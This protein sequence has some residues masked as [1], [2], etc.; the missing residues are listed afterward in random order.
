M[1]KHLYQI[2]VL[3]VL[4]AFTGLNVRAEKRIWTLADGTTFEAELVVTFPTEAVF[5]NAKGKDLKIPL[6]RLSPESRTQIE[7]EN[8][9]TLSL[10]L[11]KD[12]DA[13]VFPAGITLKMQRPPEVRCHYGIRIKQT[14]RGD[15]NRELRVELFVIGLERYGDK[16]ILLD[17]QD[18]SFFLTEGNKKEF[19][20]RS[21]RE[22]TLRN[23]YVDEVV[24]GEKYH[25]YLAIVRDVR[26]EIISVGTSHDWLFENLENLSERYVNNF[27]DKTC[28][29]VFPTRP[30]V[31]M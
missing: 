31:V 24:R 1:K 28:V 30:P 14:S 3:L 6:E 5:K 12:R 4:L 13:T 25:G 8:P 20:F 9:P 7:L 23:F 19:E 15:Y 29:R 26:G 22:V 10:G 27:M 2:S 16:Y 18:A 11:I 21:E 17:R